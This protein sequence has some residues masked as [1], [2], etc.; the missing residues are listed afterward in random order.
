MKALEVP[1]NSSNLEKIVGIFLNFLYWY[2]AAA[3]T[4]DSSFWCLEYP[5]T[6]RPE[7]ALAK[8]KDLKNKKS[9]ITCM[10]HLKQE[11]DFGWNIFWLHSIS[12]FDTHKLS[13]NKNGVTGKRWFMDPWSLDWSQIQSLTLWLACLKNC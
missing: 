3:G 13:C 9:R 8:Y 1:L 10:C 2:K 5:E 12:F 4:N 6:T 11:L 7:H